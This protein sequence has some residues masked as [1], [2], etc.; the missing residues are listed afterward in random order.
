MIIWWYVTLVAC[1]RQAAA[2]MTLARIMNRHT[3][4]HDGDAL[5]ACESI[6][7]LGRG[8]TGL[9]A[10]FVLGGAFLVLWAVL[11][12]IAGGGLTNPFVLGGGAL[13]FP[14]LLLCV[15]LPLATLTVALRRI[16]KTE[17]DEINSEIRALHGS[18]GQH[19]QDDKLLTANNQA[20]R[21]LQERWNITQDLLPTLPVPGFRPRV[22]ALTAVIE[23]AVSFFGL[24]VFAITNLL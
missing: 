10:P 3:F 19:L 18:G 6:V 24:A 16:R 12:I 15:I 9:I 20:I 23:V 4:G 7:S 13:F 11:D 2:G 17:S 1:A 21:A 8:I 22:V 5:K 14:L